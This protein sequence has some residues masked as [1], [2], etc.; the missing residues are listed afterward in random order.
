MVYFESG[1]NKITQ[2]FL[3]TP[4]CLVMK[5]IKLTALYPLYGRFS[6]W[7]WVSRYQKSPFWILL[8]LRVIEVVVTTG[9]I[10]RANLQSS[11]QIV[12]TN[13]PTLSFFLQAGCASCHP[14]ITVRALKE[15]IKL[16]ATQ[17][18]YRGC[19]KCS[20]PTLTWYDFHK[21]RSIFMIFSLLNS[22]R[23]CRGRCN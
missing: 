20:R 17:K 12:T 22:E 13:K 10:R 19:V 2:V 11:S 4:R 5:K 14:T 7:I 18:K 1:F 8:E 9:V 6:R 15:K 16:T 3:C 23:I 21:G